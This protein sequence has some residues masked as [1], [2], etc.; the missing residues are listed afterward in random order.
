[1]PWEDP[2]PEL[3]QPGRPEMRAERGMTDRDRR[4]IAFT[5]VLAAAVI[6]GVT[7]AI[8]AAYRH[9]RVVFVNDTPNPVDVGVCASRSC[10]KLG[11]IARI[12]PGK[13]HSAIGQDFRV[14]TA[15]GTTLG[16]IHARG[17][18]RRVSSAA[19]CG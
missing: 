10:D 19:P 3:E 4:W 2:H 6:A 18:T 1:M 5:V 13:R 8:V 14:L 12:A 15:D 17:T 9:T 16:C 11:T 7:V